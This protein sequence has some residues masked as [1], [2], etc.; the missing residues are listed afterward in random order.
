MSAVA[1]KVGIVFIASCLVFWLST[2]VIKLP[3]AWL[4]FEFCQYAEIGRNI[5]VDGSYST[6]LVEPMALALIDRAQAQAPDGRW[7]VVNRYPLPC[8]VI[9]ALMRMFGASESSAAWS[10][11][12]AISVLAALTYGL[13]FRW[14]GSR[15]G[16][17]TVVLFLANPAFYG[18]FILLGTPDVW[19]AALF[20]GQLAL[21]T[22][23]DFATAPRARLGWAFAL[24]TLSGLAYLARFNATLFLAAEVLFLFY[25]RRQREAAMMMLSSLVVA[26]PQFI[27]TWRHF[28]RPIVSLYSAWNLLDGVGACRVEPW[29]YYR[30][31]N[32]PA[33]LMRHFG[34][35]ARKFSTNAF[36]VVPLR[37]W[38]LWGLELVLPFALA[39]PM[40]LRGDT[41][42]RRFAAWSVVLFAIQLT[43]FSALRLELDAPPTA[44]HGRYFFWFAA[45][46]LLLGV[47]VLRW[48]GSQFALGRWLAAGVVLIQLALFGWAWSDLVGRQH[49]TNLG[50]DPIRKALT[51]FVGPDHVIAS[52]QPQLT[53]WFCGL[54]SVSL[55]A[56]LDELAR[57]NRESS[58]PAD[59]LF[60][61]MNFNA[62]DL[63][64]RWQQLTANDRGASSPWE[65]ELLE[66]Y[67]FVLPPAQT[68]PLLYV[69]LR[70]RTVRPGTLERAMNAGASAG[71]R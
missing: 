63:D 71:G 14:Y 22:K 13:A 29:L 57:L 5:A 21:F 54:R 50:R 18:E 47:G 3:P 61:D 49:E 65:A 23:L 38:T 43:A 32:I 31:P 6:R 37:I 60:V 68:R 56:D 8:V 59:Y 27:D 19:F 28:H 36:T 39:S 1:S 46:A 55:P 66:S 20:V 2:Q 15:W 9:A 58:A 24:G 17:L 69:L 64:P 11:G 10:N 35:V 45:P 25:R 44:H 52:N 42:V 53:A 16:A 12:L 67:E 33:E 48:A 41:W 34:G 70:S 4:T 30:V 51:R 26:A 7:P 40:L 62:I